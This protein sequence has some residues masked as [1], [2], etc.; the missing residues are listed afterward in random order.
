MAERGGT[1]A[2]LRATNLSR[3]LG[4][5]HRDGPTSRAAITRALGVN[6]STVASLVGELTELGIVGE[7]HPPGTGAAGRPSP[8]VAF[9]ASM[10]GV[11]IGIELDAVT[12]ALVDGHGGVVERRR[13]EHGGDLDPARMAA[14]ASGLATAMLEARPSTV[15]GVGAAV[16]GLVRT[17]DGTVRAA[18]HLGWHEVPFAEV[19]RTSF[20][21]PAFVG[22]DANLGAD[23][24]AIYGAGAGAA[25]LVYLHGGPSGIG[26]GVRVGGG[27]LPSLHGMHAEL[28][29]T[30]VDANGALCHCSGRGCLETEVRYATILEALGRESLDL[31][32]LSG[33]LRRAR[34]PALERIVER[35]LERLAIGIRTA[36]NA[37]NPER[38]VLGGF[39]GAIFDEQPDTLRSALAAQVMAPMLEGVDVVRGSLADDR[40]LVGAAELA[41]APVL[42]H[43]AEVMRQH[44]HR[45]C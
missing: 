7:T 22:N 10:V 16:P 24:E 25:C 21:M 43:P 3:V 42:E 44:V 18:P 34:G 9:D 27:A 37:F 17:T 40:L 1:A 33:E 39:L 20:G 23:A 32:D 4:L 28:G 31:A 2:Q 15:V 38:I 6:R 29:H 45:Q 12:V 35:Q 19:L 14:T 8:V 30:V 26:S 13:S 41:W 5:L 36:V 11:G